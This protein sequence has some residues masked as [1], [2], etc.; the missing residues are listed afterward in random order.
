MISELFDEKH[1]FACVSGALSERA[2]ISA[3]C[4]SLSLIEITADMYA[5]AKAIISTVRRR[6]IRRKLAGQC[7]VCAVLVITMLAPGVG[8]A[9]NGASSRTTNLMARL[10]AIATD[11]EYI[12]RNTASVA[13][14]RIRGLGYSIV[15]GEKSW[16]TSVT[17]ACNEGLSRK[18]DLVFFVNNPVTLYGM[19]SLPVGPLDAMTG[20]Y[21]YQGDDVLIVYGYTPP[22]ITYYSFTMNQK[23]LYDEADQTYADTNSSIGLSIN[24]DNIKTRNGE[25]FE[26]FFALIITA[27]SAAADLATNFLTRVGVPSQAINYMFFPRRFTDWNNEH[28]DDLGF[29]TRLTFRT[30]AEA[31]IVCGFANQTPPAMGV[32]YF[33]GPGGPGDVDDIDLQTWEDTLRENSSELDAA[34]DIKRDE[35]ADRVRL[36]FEGQGYTLKDTGIELL[37]HVDPETQCR[38]IKRACNFDA[39]DALYGQF[40]CEDENGVAKI[41]SEPLPDTSELI[42]VVGVNHHRFDSDSL[43]AYFSL[44]VTRKADLQGIATIVD[45]DTEGSAAEFAQGTNLD[46]DDFFVVRI[47][48]DCTGQA[49][50]MEVPLSAIPP[51]GSI[52]ITTRNYLDRETAAGPNPDNFVPAR[53]LRFTSNP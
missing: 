3:E 17:P 11:G 32:L 23:R 36:H 22:P 28:P 40:L 48:R 10:S 29:L 13:A 37:R 39:P 16:L 33:K 1:D 53:L 8:S 47:S 42:V 4:G 9:D 30:Q 45:L 2:S 52:L 7:S 51:T 15:R 20:I 38:L 44:A 50:C 6:F 21:P 5:A 43:N 24:Q 34:M 46:P 49:S 27:N 25:A 19:A 31:D 26:D 41:C 12:R 14:D 18:K 35:M